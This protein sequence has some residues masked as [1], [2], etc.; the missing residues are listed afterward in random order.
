MKN[1][2]SGIPA[3]NSPRIPP[4]SIPLDK[5]VFEKF[6][7]ADEPFAKASWIFETCVSV[8]I[9][10][11]RKLVLALKFPIKFDERFKITSV[12]FFVADFNLF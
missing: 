7:L 5:W 9:N 3:I 10:L 2:S 11:C 4:D 12:P 1:I 6:V 8:S